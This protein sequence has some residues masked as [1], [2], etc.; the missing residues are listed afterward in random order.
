MWKICSFHKG[1]MNQH[2][3]SLCESKEFCLKPTSAWVNLIEARIQ[4][5]EADRLKEWYWASESNQWW[6]SRAI[7]W[8]LS[9]FEFLL[10]ESLWFELQQF[11]VMGF[12]W[13]SQSLYLC[14]WCFNQHESGHLWWDWFSK[15][16]TWESAISIQMSTAKLRILFG[17]QFA[18]V[19]MKELLRSFVEL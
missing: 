9:V 16:H 17:S 6:N 12:N 7:N 5:K 1:Y 19:L 10:N 14:C 18:Q 13:N 15:S 2:S 3:I 4:F 11:Y 8:G